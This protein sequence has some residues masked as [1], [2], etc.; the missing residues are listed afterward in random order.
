M[1]IT[2]LALISALCAAAVGVNNANAVGCVSGGA[3]GAIAGHMAHHHAVL[4]AVGGCIAGHEINKHNKKLKEQEAHQ[5][6]M[7]NPSAP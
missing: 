5:Q 7:Q 6:S 3:A 4:G 1:R 2:T